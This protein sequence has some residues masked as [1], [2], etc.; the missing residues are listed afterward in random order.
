MLIIIIETKYSDVEKIMKKE[1]RFL[2]KVLKKF[3][4]AKT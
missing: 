3:T 4:I 1:S 2:E